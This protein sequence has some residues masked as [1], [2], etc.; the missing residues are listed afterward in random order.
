MTAPLTTLSDRDLLLNLYVSVMMAIEVTDTDPD[1]CLQQ[2]LQVAQPQVTD[3]TA[4]LTEIMAEVE[5]RLDIDTVEMDV[6]GEWQH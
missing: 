5:R 3:H 6:A 4:T 1:T 2:I